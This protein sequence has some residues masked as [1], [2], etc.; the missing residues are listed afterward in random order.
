MLV[1][2]GPYVATLGASVHLFSKS[3]APS[4]GEMDFLAEHVDIQLTLTVMGFWLR[5]VEHGCYC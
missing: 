4:H 1:S 3:I 5:P 2:S